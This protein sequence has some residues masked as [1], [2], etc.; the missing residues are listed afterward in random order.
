MDTD[1]KSTGETSLWTD[2]KVSHDMFNRP[3]N[4]PYW[5][6]GRVDNAIKKAAFWFAFD[7]WI[8]YMLIEAIFK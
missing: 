7:F 2:D 5:H 3:E 4:S 8:G 6:W 1:T